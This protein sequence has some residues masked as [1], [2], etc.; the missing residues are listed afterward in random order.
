LQ[1]GKKRG[2]L[3]IHERLNPNT[4]QTMKKHMLFAMV[5]LSAVACKESTVEPEYTPDLSNVDPLIRELR[6]KRDFR[7][8]IEG[9]AEWDSLRSA[10]AAKTQMGDTNPPQTKSGPTVKNIR[11]YDS[12]TSTYTDYVDGDGKLV[13]VVVTIGEFNSSSNFRTD[14]SMEAIV[15]P[16]MMNRPDSVHVITGVAAKASGETFQAW[17]VTARKIRG[18]GS[19]GSERLF[20]STGALGTSSA[21]ATVLLPTHSP[22][23]LVYVAAGVGVRI[24]NKVNNLGLYMV[25]YNPATKSLVINSVNDVIVLLPQ[26]TATPLTSFERQIRIW[27]CT[28]NLEDMK[29]MIVSGF[30]GRN[31]N[32]SITRI[33]MKI[34]NLEY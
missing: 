2:A 20:K 13:E 9:S 31:N 33:G 19:L 21:D 26:E 24:H 23:T 3:E 25:P 6:L 17:W 18:D 11:Y 5:L 8:V 14:N 29:R 12:S 16:D 10:L 32:N 34:V 4:N 7:T 28:S 22:N 30:G 27:D 15:L 1:E